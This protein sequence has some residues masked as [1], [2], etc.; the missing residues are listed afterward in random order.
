MRRLAV[1]V[2]LVA[3]VVL[4]AAFVADRV[5]QERT[6]ERVL[7]AAAEEVQLS[8][9]E[10]EIFGFPFLT[11]VLANQLAE[12]RGTAE[13]V[14]V[15]GMVLTDVRVTARGVTA[16]EPHRA[17]TVEVNATVPV[18]TLHDELAGAAGT[19]GGAFDLRSN[20][21]DLV[22][23]I[24]V[25]GVELG[26]VLAPAVVDG[27][28]GLEVEDVVVGDVTVLPDGV[29]E[30]LSAAVSELRLTVPDL[31]DG[32]EPTVVEVL[33]DGVRVRLEGED[34]ELD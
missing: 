9:A 22:L 7:A 33:P 25:A 5:S 10:L 30:A 3:P 15:D 28:I 18:E 17:E 31:P 11:Q 13:S 16:R 14:A 24:E 19:L 26:V 8:G 23:G 20:G 4:A 6:E 1:I 29:R 21:S 34:V 32:L 27:A 2:L 12:V